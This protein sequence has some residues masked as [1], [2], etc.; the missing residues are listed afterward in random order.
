MDDFDA[1]QVRELQAIISA[2]STT[3]TNICPLRGISDHC[4]WFNFSFMRSY[5]FSPHTESK[6]TS[7]DNTVIRRP[8]LWE[9]MA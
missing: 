4:G 5:I 2:I 6:Y 1:G 9:Y 3:I 7:V 8:Y